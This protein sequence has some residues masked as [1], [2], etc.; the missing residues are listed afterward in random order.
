MSPAGFILCLAFAAIPPLTDDQRIRVASA[1][2]GRDHRE[3][4]FVALLDNI[5]QWTPGVGDAPLRLN[6]DLATM[7]QRPD[8]HRGE[9]CR[10]TGRIQQQSRLDRP[11]QNVLE[12][13]IRDEGDRAI[14]VYVARLERSDQFRDGQQVMILA[15][16]Y[17]RVD[18]TA[19]DGKVRGYPAL[20]GAFPTV[21]GSGDE[22]WARLWVVSG[23]VLVMLVAFLLLLLYARRGRGPTR[24]RA[25]PVV[26]P[27]VDETLPDDPAEAL[28]E[29]RRRAG[30]AD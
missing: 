5:R 13:F 30:T 12:W 3:E 21:I 6:P 27:A 7:L 4:A 8:A 25:R 2:D 23:P 22:G 9:L 15:R 26:G 20:V 11:H 24:R 28:A 29:L 18:A 19:R 16:F 14:L 10:I 1:H 17:K